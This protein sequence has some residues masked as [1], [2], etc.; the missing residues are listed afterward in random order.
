L[1]KGQGFIPKIKSIS[2][3]GLTDRGLAGVRF[4]RSFTQSAGWAKKIRGS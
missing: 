4:T 2:F 1:K 3:K